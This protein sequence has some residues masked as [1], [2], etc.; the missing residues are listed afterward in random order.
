MTRPEAAAFGL[1]SSP[2]L[3]VQTLRDL[4]TT[5]DILLSLPSDESV[6]GGSY[7]AATCLRSTDAEP[8]ERT[9]PSVARE[10]AKRAGAVGA[11]PIVGDRTQGN[12]RHVR[13][14]ERQ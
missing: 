4:R 9:R 6:S 3:P 13:G 8:T 14:G 2:V 5:L 7:E 11:E 1:Q 10:G 12:H